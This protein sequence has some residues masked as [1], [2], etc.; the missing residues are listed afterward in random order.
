MESRSGN[1]ANNH[2]AKQTENIVNIAIAFGMLQKDDGHKHKHDRKQNDGTRSQQGPKN[3]LPRFVASIE[4]SGISSIGGSIDAH[5]TRGHL[6][7]SENISKLLRGKPKVV[8]SHLAL[9]K[10]NHGIAATE[11]EKSDLKERPEKL[12]KDHMRQVIS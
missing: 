4:N 2:F 10:S 3:G 11:S 8:D 6:A 7:Y 1:K 5:R 9:Y 12:Q